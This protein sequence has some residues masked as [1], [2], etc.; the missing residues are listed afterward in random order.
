MMCY[1]QDTCP[2]LDESE[3]TSTNKF[4]VILVDLDQGGQKNRY[5]KHEKK[6]FFPQRSNIS[7][8]RIILFTCF[9]L[10]VFCK[11][12]INQDHRSEFNGIGS[13]LDIIIINT[14]LKRFLIIEW[15]R[16]GLLGGIAIRTENRTIWYRVGQSTGTDRTS[17]FT[18]A[19]RNPRV[20]TPTRRGNEYPSTRGR[21]RRV[22]C[23]PLAGLEHGRNNASSSRSQRPNVT[24]PPPP[25]AGGIRDGPP[26]SFFSSGFDVVT[27]GFSMAGYA[28]FYTAQPP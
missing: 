5:E 4:F 8:P 19:V 1:P 27:R 12:Y 14:L 10:A 3:S 20:E 24:A 15:S 22:R 25:L 18:L 11:N 7:I 13:W 17:L 6:R 28:V 21:T 2:A 9:T 26:F 23:H 16:L